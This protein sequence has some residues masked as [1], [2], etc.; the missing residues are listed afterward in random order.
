MVKN[1]LLHIINS[2]YM[3]SF[4]LEGKEQKNVCV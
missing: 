4:E 3:Y 1:D 2:K